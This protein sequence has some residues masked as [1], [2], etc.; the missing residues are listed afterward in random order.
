MRSGAGLTDVRIVRPMRHGWSELFALVLDVERYPRFVPH[1]R[2]VRVLLRDAVS[3][4]RTVVISRMTVGWSALQVG[5]ANRTVADYDRRSIKVD[6][7]DGP[8]RYLRVA[9]D[10]EPQSRER[11]TVSFAAEYE[12]SNPIL[13]GLASRLFGAMFGEIVTAFERQADSLA[14]SARN[15]AEDYRRVATTT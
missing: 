13:A 7:I 3:P 8:F 11:T 9:W 14:R 4:T 2:D 10:F 12:F 15:A 5:Y 6:A 1:C